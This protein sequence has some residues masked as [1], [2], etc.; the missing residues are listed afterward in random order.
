MKTALKFGTSPKIDK[1]ISIHS[2]LL[3]HSWEISIKHWLEIIR[4][5]IFI[6]KG[7]LPVKIK[8]EFG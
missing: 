7:K 6:L 2:P 1:Y 8:C 3:L 5:C 4:F